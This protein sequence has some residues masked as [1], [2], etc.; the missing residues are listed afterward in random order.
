VCWDGDGSEFV[1][2][3]SS[4]GKHIEKKEKEGEKGADRR[5]RDGRVAQEESRFSDWDR[6]GRRVQHEDPLYSM[7][8]GIDVPFRHR[9]VPILFRDQ[10]W[11]HLK[12]TR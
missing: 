11:S 6:G 10:L 7:V 5:N 1:S 12:V 4:I 2:S 3:L 9:A 8:A